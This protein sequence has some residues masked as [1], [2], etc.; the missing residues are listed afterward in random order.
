MPLLSD[1]ELLARLV[2]FDTASPNGNAPVIDFLSE[3]LDRPG[4][5]IQRLPSPDLGK[6]NLYVEVGPEPSGDR[7]GVLLSGHTDVV[8]AGEPEWASS[9]FKLTERNGNL[10]G[11]GAADMKGFVA[12]AT[13]LA[14]EIDPASLQAPLVL[15]F[16]YDEEVG[17]LGARHFA[18]TWAAPA[19]LPRHAIIGEPTRLQVV[20]AHKGFI[21]LRVTFL[22][23]SAHSGYPHLGRSAIEPAATA[24]TALATLRHALEHERPDNAALFPEVPFVPLNVGTIHGGSAPNVIPDHCTLALTMRP[25]P[26]MESHQLIERVRDVLAR[27]ASAARWTLDVV[28]ESPP[29]LTPTDAPVLQSLLELVDP[30]TPT[31]VSY[32]TDAGWLQKLDLDCVIF[33]PGDIATAHRPN[34]FVPEADLVAARAVLQRLIERL[35]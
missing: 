19:R 27:A 30:A 23:E 32:A 22:G 5:R 33:G 1:T 35:C 31:T 20:H 10:Y 28:C 26:G 8:P 7:G 13:N 25:L 9:P 15:L 14:A 6:A 34:E 16:T 18:E 12:L 17:T 29:M 11:R 4:V 21:E 24:V 3:Y 2:A